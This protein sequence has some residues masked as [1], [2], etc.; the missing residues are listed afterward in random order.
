MFYYDRDFSII[1]YLQ[2]ND[3]IHRLSQ[4]HDCIIYDLYYEDSIEDLILTRLEEKRQDMERIFS[5]A[6]QI[7]DGVLKQ[8]KEHLQK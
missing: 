4:K 6:K 3:R 7:N 1:K 8:I 5:G 2:S